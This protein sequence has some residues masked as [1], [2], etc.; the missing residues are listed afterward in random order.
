MRRR[1]D[2]EKEIERNE[3][4]RLQTAVDPQDDLESSSSV[5]H[6]LDQ[7]FDDSSAFSVTSSSMQSS[8]VEDPS[9]RL[10]SLEDFDPGEYW[11][12]LQ[13]AMLRDGLYRQSVRKLFMNR[14][15]L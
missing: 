3:L 15:Y 10:S 11:Y 13:R 2:L 6:S 1:I 9:Q 4:E 14:L 5:S 7:S 12:L 8:V